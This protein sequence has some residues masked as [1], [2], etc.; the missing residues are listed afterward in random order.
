MTKLPQT[1]IL[2]F[3]EDFFNKIPHKISHWSNLCSFCGQI[4]I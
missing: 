1:K 3:C 4:L 2:S